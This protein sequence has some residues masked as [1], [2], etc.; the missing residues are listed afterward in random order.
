MNHG[1]EAVAKQVASSLEKNN[2]FEQV[3]PVE[4]SLRH[5]A[6]LNF[7]SFYAATNKNE[8]LSSRLNLFTSPWLILVHILSRTAILLPI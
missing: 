4:I 1:L 8:M 5:R 2:N 6:D 7:L 3:Y